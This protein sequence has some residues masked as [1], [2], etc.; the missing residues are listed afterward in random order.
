MWTAGSSKGKWFIKKFWGRGANFKN[1]LIFL[2]KKLIIKKTQYKFLI[3]K[4]SLGEKDLISEN[5]ERE[6]RMMVITRGNMVLAMEAGRK[7]Q[8]ALKK[9][10]S[11]RVNGGTKNITHEVK[12]N[13]FLLKILINKY[14]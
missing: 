9:K 3:I 13:S 8:E 2:K 11:K 7:E 14:H 4:L 1:K 10:I 12:N 5:L 6:E